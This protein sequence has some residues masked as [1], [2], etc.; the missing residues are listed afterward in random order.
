MSG[1]R[2]AEPGAGR[3]AGAPPGAG[4]TGA[5]PGAGPR[6]VRL[7]DG[8]LVPLDAGRL[9]AAMRRAQAAAGEDDPRFAEEVVDIVLL[10]LAARLG[11]PDSGGA[12]RA[13][14]LDELHDLVERALIELGRARVAKAYIVQRDRRDRAREALLVHDV[15]TRAAGRAPLVRHGGGTAPWNPARIVAALMKEAELPREMAEEVA[16]R[17]ERRVFDAR[18]RRLSTAL[19]REFVDNELGAMGLG[20]ALLR[21]EPVGVPR[22]D[23]RG[24]L[25]RPR[26]READGPADF[27]APPARFEG[28]VAGEVLRRWCLEDVL[29]EAVADA[30][31]DGRLHVL[32][33]ARPHQVLV[34][35]IP[36]ELL[37]RREPGLH[38]AHEVLGEAASLVAASAL[39]VVLED[40]HRVVAPMLR[41]TRSSAGLRDVLAAIGAV[42]RAA[43]RRLDLAAP[44][45]RSGTLV[46]RLLPELATLFAEGAAAPRLFLA[47]DEL[48]PAVEAAGPARDAAEA[49]VAR[50]RVIPVWH[51]RNERWVAPGCRRRGREQV[52]LACGGAVAVNLPRL[53]RGVGPWREDLLFEALAETV[54]LALDALETLDGLQRELRQSRGELLRERL[55]YAITPVG[56][57]EALRILGDG[58][59]RPGQGARLLGVLAEATRRFSEA[60]DLEVVLSSL[61][62]ARARA[63]FAARDGREPRPAQPRLFADMPSP[64][65]ERALRYG[66]GYDLGE[67]APGAGAAQAELL[68]TVPSGALF[69]FCG[70]VS[71]ASRG[72]HPHLAAWRRFDALRQPAPGAG[73]AHAPSGAGP[74]FD[75]STLRR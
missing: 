60:R 46:G 58:E 42:G 45:G 64:E 1:A 40:L 74:L 16:G 13:P 55:S 27:D 23:L 36:T 7:A 63:R 12:P 35:S 69:P 56:L 66:A 6:E 11:Q 22:H 37:L 39:G 20:A 38:A 70:L 67:H 47:W 14:A 72:D 50:G 18:L 43:G 25:H 21:Q 10:A 51:A 30:H 49:L 2:E 9:Q 53:A 28:A 41:A 29:S 24:L 61:F 65:A 5:P 34:R 32:D 17:V 3:G 33:V 52:A 57:A 59:V 73:R 19:I 62:G 54:R 68:S 44:G 15:E 48:A 8:R 31:K 26:A 75:G 71:E 4:P